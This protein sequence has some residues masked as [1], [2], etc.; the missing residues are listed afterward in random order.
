MSKIREF[1]EKRITK[2]EDN[3]D[4][5]ILYSYVL[6]ASSK[7]FED[8]LLYSRIKMAVA[9]CD[10]EINIWRSLIGEKRDG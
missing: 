8:S 10:L 4:E 1:I 5:F 7:E 3:K 9:L 2:I 6:K